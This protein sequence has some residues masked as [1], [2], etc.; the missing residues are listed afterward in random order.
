MFDL[1]LPAAHGRAAVLST[2][3]PTP[4]IPDG[5]PPEDVDAMRAMLLDLLT[6]NPESAT[7]TSGWSR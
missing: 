5:L 6:D 7:W 4:T 1:W 2:R 3:M